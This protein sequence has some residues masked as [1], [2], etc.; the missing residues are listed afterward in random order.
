MIVDNSGDERIAAWLESRAAERLR[1][2]RLTPRLDS[3]RRS[4][5]HR[6]GCGEVVILF[7][8]AWI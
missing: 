6:G 8:S 2:V 1:S 5:R 3:R 7:D 4:T